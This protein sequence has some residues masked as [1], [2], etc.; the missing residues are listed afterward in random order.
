MIYWTY[1]SITPNINRKY[2]SQFEI[3]ISIFPAQDELSDW[4]YSGIACGN[5]DIP[6][7]V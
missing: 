7:S 1:V 5:A 4:T 3:L 6:T 2:L